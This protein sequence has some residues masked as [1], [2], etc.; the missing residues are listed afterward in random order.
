VMDCQTSM[1]LKGVDIPTAK[2][3]IFRALVCCARPLRIQLRG[4]D[5]AI[6]EM[7]DPVAESRGLGVVGDHEHGLAQFAIGAL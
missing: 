4:D 7:K 3:W 5:L 2:L 6:T 1:P